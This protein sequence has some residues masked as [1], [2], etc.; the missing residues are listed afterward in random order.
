MRITA[1]TTH[2]VLIVLHAVLL[3]RSLEV[4][5]ALMT[6][7]CHEGGHARHLALWRGLPPRFQQQNAPVILLCQSDSDGSSGTARP[8]C[9]EIDTLIIM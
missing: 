3:R 5:V 7:H 9:Q 6:F 1:L 8:N 4:P 2:L